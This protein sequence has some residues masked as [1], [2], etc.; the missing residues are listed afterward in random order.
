MTKIKQSDFEGDTITKVEEPL[1]RYQRLY[2]W[3]KANE[4]AYKA[5]CHS[6][7]MCA[8]SKAEM[9][10]IQQYNGNGPPEL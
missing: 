9:L 4:E 3:R 10:L 7:C 8:P 2:E 5:A 6:E 1:T